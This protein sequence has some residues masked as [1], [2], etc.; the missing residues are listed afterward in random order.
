MDQKQF[1]YLLKQNAKRKKYG[2]ILRDKNGTIVSDSDSIIEI[3][4]THFK[5]L[6]TP[7]N[8]NNFDEKFR[9]KVEEEVRHFFNSV[10]EMNENVL[11]NPIT[12]EE[13][14]KF[15]ES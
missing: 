4:E 15:V 13:V 6:A 5:E 2:N 1:W 8:N 14:K 3:W 11:A 9:K 10:E 7:S 12:T